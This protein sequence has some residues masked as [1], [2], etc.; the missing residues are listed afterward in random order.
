MN[1][2]SRS[3]DK[4]NEGEASSLAPLQDAK[5]PPIG[6]KRAFRRVVRM[7]WGVWGAKQPPQHRKTIKSIHFKKLLLC[8]MHN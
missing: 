3:Y 2:K 4:K 7:L 5:R 1:W 6:R 8:H